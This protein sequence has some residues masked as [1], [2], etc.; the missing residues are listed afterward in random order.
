MSSS[1]EMKRFGE[2]NRKTALQRKAKNRSGP[3]KAPV[4][5][6]TPEQT[7]LILRMEVIVARL[8]NES[9]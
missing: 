8:L 7:A 6:S 4:C 5:T 9:F 3:Q 2:Q 1:L